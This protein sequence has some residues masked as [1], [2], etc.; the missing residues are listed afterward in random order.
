MSDPWLA[1]RINPP[2]TPNAAASVAVARPMYMDPITT[3]ISMIT[4]IRNREFR[5]RSAKVI[6]GSSFGFHFLETTDVMAT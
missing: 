2:I 3:M 1:A 4:G 6:G 5:T